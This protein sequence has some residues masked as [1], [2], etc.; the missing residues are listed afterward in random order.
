MVYCSIIPIEFITLTLVKRV[1]NVTINNLHSTF[2]LF[3]ML[4]GIFII[5][6]DQV[7]MIVCS[8]QI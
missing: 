5:N 1:H 6:R 7:D 8:S 3:A 4:Y 2:L